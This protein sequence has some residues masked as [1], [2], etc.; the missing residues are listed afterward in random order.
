MLCDLSGHDA[1]KV[2]RPQRNSG[3][4]QST[5]NPALAA[6]GGR[7]VFQAV[8]GERTLIVAR[9]A[10]GATHPVVRGRRAG[11][12]RFGDPYDPVLSADG[13]RL[14]YTQSGGRVGDPRS[15]RSWVQVRDVRTGRL[16]AADRSGTTANPGLSPD[17]RFVAYV[18]T[19]RGGPR[20]AGAARPR[21]RARAAR[22]RPAA[23]CRWTRS[24]PTAA[25]WWPSPRSRDGRSEIRAWT[26]AT[27]TVQVVSRAG[28]PAGAVAD[29]W[30]EGPSISGDG[31]RIAFASTA[32][33]LDAA[34]HDDTRAIFVRDLAAGSTR[35][36]SDV[37]AA[38]A[39]G[40]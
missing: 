3:D 30:S 10:A 31:R 37:A 17:G 13:A 9:D 39:V 19:P 32:T 6:D 4:S 12:A 28:G 25:P 29:G 5:Y 7:L 33:N 21:V 8:A 34:K 26:A 40:G 15:A 14:A 18:S 38:Y 20:R 23:R 27:G 1:T 16:L 2:D 36:V 22:S 35:L 11:G 24:S